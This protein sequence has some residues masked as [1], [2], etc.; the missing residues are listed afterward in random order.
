MKAKNVVIE[1]T[2]S[3]TYIVFG[4]QNFVTILKNK[5]IIDEK[6]TELCRMNDRFD[7]FHLNIDGDWFISLTYGNKYLDVR[8]YY[9][10]QP[11][12]NEGVKLS[13]LDWTML[14]RHL[15]EIYKFRPDLASTGLLF[16]RSV[17]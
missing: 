4:I 3:N 9:D 12:S 11:S 6:F 8:K 13:I 1:N 17:H 16:K 7:N 5:T 10:N 15:A 2:K 14:K